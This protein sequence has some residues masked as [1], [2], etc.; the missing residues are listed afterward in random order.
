MLGK[1]S[2][3]S[4]KI[5]SNGNNNGTASLAN[6]YSRKANTSS[7]SKNQQYLEKF[8]ILTCK[9]N[10]VPSS[11]FLCDIWRR[12]KAYEEGK[13]KKREMIMK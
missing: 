12:F 6:L 13:R 11:Q 9:V 4:K 2:W 3:R 8:I 1:E 5:P 7:G 10:R